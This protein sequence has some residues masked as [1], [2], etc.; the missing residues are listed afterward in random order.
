MLLFLTDVAAQ[1]VATTDANPP[2]T[3]GAKGGPPGSGAT[4]PPKAETTAQE[5][6]AP[7]PD[8]PQ[9]GQLWKNPKDGLEYLW[10]PPGT[11]QMGCSPGNGHFY[12]GCDGDEQPR[13]AITI[14]RGFWMGKTEVTVRAYKRFCSETKRPM[15]PAPVFNSGW[16]F[17]DHPMVNITWDDAVA[18]C[19]WTSGRLPTESEWEYACRAGS[20]KR[21]YWGDSIDPAYCWYMENA[22]GQTHPV[23]QKSPNRFGLYDTLGNASEYCSDWYHE[24]SYQYSV[25]KDPVGPGAGKLRIIRGGSWQALPWG[26]R[27]SFRGGVLPGE[28]S[29]GRCDYCGFRSVIP[30]K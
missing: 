10:I 8:N 24:R 25:A 11:F 21:F 9:P 26:T 20:D 2:A 1:P 16:G 7:L 17:E 6:P 27:A 3:E 19:Q 5:G 18:F 13:H 28:G 15:P 4:P 12:Y 14:T 30:G 23:A 22:G 29:A